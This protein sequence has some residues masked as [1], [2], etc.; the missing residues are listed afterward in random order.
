MILI[1][2][3]GPAGCAAATV[4]ARAG[5]DVLMVDALAQ[6]AA[7]IGESLLPFGNRVLELM[8]VDMSG[9]I[10]KHGAVFTRGD[11]FV[12]FPF[13]ESARP[14]WSSAYEVPRDDF[15]ARLRQVALQAGARFEVAKAR[16][17][18]LDRKVLV[19][20]DREIPFDV[21]IDAAGRR[22]FLARQLDEID[23]HPDLKNAAIHGQFRGVGHPD[24][25]V[26]GDITI[27]EF[28]GGWFWFIPFSDGR[29]SVGMVMTPDAGFS[30]P[31][32]A[33]WTEGLERCPQAR[34]RLED[35]E[36]VDRLGGVQDFTSY[37]RRFSGDGWALAGDAALFLD[38]VFSS[39]V[40][41]ALESGWT[42]GECL[43]DDGDLAAWEQSI[44]DAAKPMELAVLAWYDGSFL[45]VACAP[46]G[47]Q[48]KRFRKAIISLLAGDL[49]AP[50]ND[51]SRRMAQKFQWLA[52]LL[53][54][55]PEA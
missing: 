23:L 9:F 51:A 13:A 20:A 41:F 10:V 52:G 38:P 5:R 6:P 3:A 33:R 12:R 16:R 8:G 39:G 14:T 55:A 27:T 28:R 35:A 53:D 24:P 29:T 4:L 42:L 43:R 25:A 48:K 47:L 15:D 34:R 18:D 49:F 54:Q 11:A 50:G 36:I 22:K 2:G 44:R 46:R 30:G 7:A 32:Q 1:L 19:C 40:L 31:P 45:D 17:V 21:F 26:S 37:A